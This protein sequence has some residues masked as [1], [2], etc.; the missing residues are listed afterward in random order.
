MNT[1]LYFLRCTCSSRYW[2]YCDVTSIIE[3]HVGLV[4]PKTWSVDQVTLPLLMIMLTVKLKIISYIV[5][6]LKIS[7]W[8]FIC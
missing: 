8:S 1:A 5:F 6:M 7:I 3:A 2:C 4:A